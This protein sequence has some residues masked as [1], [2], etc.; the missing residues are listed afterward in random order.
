MSGESANILMLLLVKVCAASLMTSQLLG[1]IAFHP[2]DGTSP[3]S[4]RRPAKTITPL[5]EATQGLRLE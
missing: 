3:L 4:P 1:A 2:K 5:W